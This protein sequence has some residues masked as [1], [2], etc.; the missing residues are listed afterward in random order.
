LQTDII[1]LPR[2]WNKIQIFKF[3]SVNF[4]KVF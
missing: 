4:F 3:S 1:G 2:W